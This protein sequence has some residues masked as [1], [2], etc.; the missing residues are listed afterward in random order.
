MKIKMTALTD[1]GRERTNNED[2]FLVCPDLGGKK[3]EGTVGYIPLADAGAV[4]IVADGMG[5]P[6]AGEVASTLAIETVQKCFMENPIPELLSDEAAESVLKAF[7]NKANEALHSRIDS[8][9]ETIGMGTTIVILWLLG[10]SAHIAW[11]GD[12]RCYVFHPKRGLRLLTKDH[13]YVQEMVDRGEITQDEAF[14]HPDSNIITR[15]LGDVDDSSEVET[16]TYHVEEGDVF[17]LC[18]DGLCGYC[19]DESIEKVLSSSWKDL[20]K[21]QVSLLQLALQA[22]GYDNITISLLATTPDTSDTGFW[23]KCKHFFRP[24]CNQ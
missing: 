7:V 4:A 5:G 18:S 2:S 13:S 1:V 12:S 24:S 16:L 3:W 15:G 20:E 14:N 23:S 6:V 11:C 10:S 22:G 21:C 17:L 19:R 8:D 9:P